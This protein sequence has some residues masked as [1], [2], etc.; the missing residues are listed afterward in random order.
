M[1]FPFDS[2]QYAD[3]AT[4][5]HLSPDPPYYWLQGMKADNIVICCGACNSSRGAKQLSDW[6]QT[7]Y[8]AEKGICAESV[9]EPVKH[10]LLRLRS[11]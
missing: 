4:I 3:S 6:F 10:Y 2:R 5:E 11:P 7:S 8:C 9:A 1:V